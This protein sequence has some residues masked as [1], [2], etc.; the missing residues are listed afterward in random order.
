MSKQ[1]Q[2]LRITFFLFTISTASAET[3]TIVTDSSL[4]QRPSIQASIVQQLEA[5]TQVDI[6]SR[7]GGWKQISINDDTGGWVR[8][9]QVRAG[10]FTD[11][12]QEQKSGG[13]F[14]GLASLSRMASGLFSS[15]NKKGY[16]FQNT[17]TIGVRGLSEEQIKNAKANLNELKKMESYR[18]NRRSTQKYARKGHLS[19]IKISHMPKS[20]AEK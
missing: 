13:F 17:A 4:Y 3:A 1:K 10:D 7:L 12:K 19:A 20:R 15:S 6:E 9:Y 8:S 16:S 14:S 5:G 18:V 11:I 2:T